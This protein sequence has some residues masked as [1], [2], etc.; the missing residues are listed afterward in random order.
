[1]SEPVVCP[2]CRQRNEQPP[3]CRRC[4]ADLSL[5]FALEAQRT[6]AL[7]TGFRALA[8]GNADEALTQADR[9]EEMRI[10]TDAR[11]LRALAHLL[12]REFDAAL[13]VALTTAQ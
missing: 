6:R 13:S 3:L 8:E 7:T 12:R 9:T 2:V 5:L 10:G 11:R 4:K 1:V